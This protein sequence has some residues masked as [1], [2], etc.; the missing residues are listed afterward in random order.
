MV[1]INHYLGIGKEGENIEVTTASGSVIIENGKVLLDKHGDDE[2]WK[3]PGGKQLDTNNFQENT[4]KEVKEELGIEVT[5]KGD[6]C[7]LIFE[8]EHN[9][10][11]EYVILIHYLA[12]RLTEETTK[13][14][15]IREY[16]WIEVK[17]LPSD[18]APN[19]KP[20]LDYFLKK[21]RK[22]FI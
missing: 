14:K 6:P 21:S 19:I 10:V 17:N 1:E 12:D 4:I 16:K 3:F 15:D 8:R 18:C 2:F 5:P 9:K 7:I 11:K 13:D 22:L 20:V